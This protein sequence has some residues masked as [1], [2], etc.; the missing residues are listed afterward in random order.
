MEEPNRCGAILVVDDDGAARELL[1][2]VLANAGYNAEPCA[3]AQ[4]ALESA[5]RSRPRLAILDVCM[6][7][8]SGYELCRRLR[9]LY[10]D[11]LPV[12]FLS[13]ERV[14]AVD[15]SAGLLLGGDDYLVKPYSPDEL[16]ARVVSL[17]RRT[18]AE[19][20]APSLT[21]R[22][23]S[24][25]ELLAEGLS[26]HEIAHALVISP[27]TVSTHLTRIYEKLGAR[28]RVTALRTAYLSGILQPL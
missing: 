10:G 16:V 18:S 12:L 5:E 1:V 2:D 27:K 28:D 14:D 19:T 11:G 24:V 8:V 15:R 9:D 13:G 20:E 26:R 4:A 3:S 25:L 21:A 22:E 23:R 17:L 7:G 6:P